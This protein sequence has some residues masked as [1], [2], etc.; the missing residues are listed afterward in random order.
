MIG[1]NRKDKIARAL[2]LSAGLVCVGLGA[3]GMVLPILPTTPFLL[4]AAAC[5][6]KSSPRMYN[7][8]LTNKWFGGYIRNYREG[9]GLPI[10]TKITALTVLWA[11]I[12]VSIVFFLNRLLPEQLVF[13]FQL[14]MVAVAIGVSVKIL[15]IPTFK[16]R[17]SG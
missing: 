5:F 2:W 1:Q 4:A 13:P 12:M 17:I 14:I 7:W 9:R 16:K 3:V 6:C 11:T 8:L 10:R 15:R